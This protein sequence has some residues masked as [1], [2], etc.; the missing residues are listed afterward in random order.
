MFLQFLNLSKR[1]QYSYSEQANDHDLSKHLSTHEVNFF[2]LKGHL[3]Y[4]REPPSSSCF[5]LI[6]IKNASKLRYDMEWSIFCYC[7]MQFIAFL[8]NTFTHV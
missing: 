8:Y 3:N 7:L 1:I 6:G 4:A 5:S 2:P